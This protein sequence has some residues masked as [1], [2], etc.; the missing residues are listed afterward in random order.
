MRR[1]LATENIEA[2][3]Y[4]RRDR[5]DCQI[6][7]RSHFG[8]PFR[9]S[10]PGRIEA[11]AQIA[12]A[13]YGNAPA[14]RPLQKLA[15]RRPVLHLLVGEDLADPTSVPARAPDQR[16]LKNNATAEAELERQIPEELG[17]NAVAGEL[18]ARAPHAPLSS[19]KA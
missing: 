6:E 14:G 2:R 8:A 7:V 9:C 16:A 13:L 12:D 17:L 11:G 18:S 5:P 3:I 10:R 1:G 4:H 15:E 19:T